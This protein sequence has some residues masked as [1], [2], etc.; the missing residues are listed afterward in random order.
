[1]F[2]KAAR[3][4]GFVAPTGKTELNRDANVL[5]HNFNIKMFRLVNTYCQ[6]SMGHVT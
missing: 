6:A 5:S 1:M 3:H 4:Y 2:I